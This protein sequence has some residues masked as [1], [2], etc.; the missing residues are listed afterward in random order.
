MQAGFEASTDIVEVDV[1][2]IIDGQFTVF[3]GRMLDHRTNGSGVTLEHCMA[4]PKTPG[5]SYCYIAEKSFLSGRG[6]GLILPLDE[7][8][9]A[10]PGCVYRCRTVPVSRIAGQP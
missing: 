5:L 3:Q 7:V 9:T 10:F 4:E 1:H 8:L 2:T 6:S